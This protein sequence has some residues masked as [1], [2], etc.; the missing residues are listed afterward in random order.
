MIAS[1][2][3]VGRLVWRP[4]ALYVLGFLVFAG[5]WALIQAGVALGDDFPMT[6]KPAIA[7]IFWNGSVVFM[8]VLGL[9]LAWLTM[10]V[11]QSVFAFSVPSL[12]GKVARG[13]LAIGI[14]TAVAIACTVW[15]TA[16]AIE[17]AGS[18]CAAL[19]FFAV[20]WRSFNLT[21]TQTPSAF[22]FVFGIVVFY[23]VERTRGLF[24]VSPML[25]A[26][27]CLVGAAF[28][29]GRELSV[30]TARARA[31]A[32]LPISIYGTLG[33]V[34]LSATH[35][36]GGALFRGSQS[37]NRL[38]HWV[39]AIQYENAGFRR[40]G[41]VTFVTWSALTISVLGYADNAT[42]LVGF[43]G[44]QT[45]AILASR[46]RGRLV[47]PLS[48]K[49]RA[50]SVFIATVLN[51]VLYFAIAWVV[52]AVLTKAA[53]PKLWFAIDSGS[54]PEGLDSL[55]GSFIWTPVVLL[56]GATRTLP[57]SPRAYSAS[58]TFGLLGLVLLAVLL[59]ASTIYLLKVAAHGNSFIWAGLAS[60]AALTV[61]GSYW[62][63][64]RKHFAGKN[65]I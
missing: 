6:S 56:F 9:A 32:P 4:A 12:V 62:V 18:L 19:L 45:S 55:G 23:E 60:L 51:S 34:R 29:I 3:A 2:R 39:K 63:V 30:A 25:I 38:V 15:W 47:Y 65:L 24:L 20:G 59:A 8:G 16:G 54:R 27:G 35:I 37:S 31:S 5:V 64:L 53:A 1:L 52:L 36:R 42:Y 40:G 50:D 33:A 49:E 41:W 44:M 61:Y 26:M 14:I 17:G 22:F 13:T 43:L 57:K 58:A 7:A 21:R 11:R 48:R 10:P 28:L 46:L